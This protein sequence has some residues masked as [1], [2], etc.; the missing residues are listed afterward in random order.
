ML[1]NRYVRT[2]ILSRL[3]LQL[4]I[5]IR[6]YG[7]LLYVTETTGNNPI[8]VS[9]ISVA[10]F[11]P[12]FLFA[13][14][15]GTLADRW[16]PRRTMVWSDL[17]SALSVVAVWLLVLQG[18]W[19]MLLVGSF[20]SAS[21]SQLSQPSAMKLYKR[22]VPE[23]QLQAV[24]SLSQSLIAIFTILGPAVGT[25]I[26]IRF[27]IDVT[28]IVTALLFLG[29]SCILLGLPR[30]QQQVEQSDRQGF[31]H[32]L[33]DGLHYI[34]SSRSLRTL[35][36]TFA[37]VG[38]AS[39]LTQPLQIFLVIEQLGLDKSFLQWFLMVNGAAMLAGG[40][41]ITGLARKMQPHLMLI[42][43]LLVSAVCTAGIGASRQMILT[44]ALLAISGFFYPCIQGGIQTLM[45]RN[46]ETAFIG[47]VTGTMMP[48]FMGMMVTG[49]LIS[50]YFKESF[51]LFS[52]YLF[53][54][55]LIVIGALVLLPFVLRTTQPDEEK[56]AA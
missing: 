46:T 55:G 31:R 1:A 23:A 42:V 54:G 2:I 48:V 18:G 6:N 9:L 47:R 5:W 30:D 12:I 20:I 43:G 24:M 19:V 15:G 8:D 26:F 41:I 11:A 50:G 51:S 39:G 10:E 40:I 17:L 3:L 22:H 25:F 52:V 45:I 28:L 38:L 21:L 32:E 56:R 33:R 13:L 53:S 27:G 35:S 44:F 7:V 36:L 29:S 37:A 14:I 34:R 16:Q 49:M 4:G